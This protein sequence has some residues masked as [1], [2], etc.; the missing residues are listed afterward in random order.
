MAHLTFIHGIANKAAKERLEEAWLA[1]LRDAGG[2]DLLTEGV[3]TST[4]YWADVL[5]PHPLQDSLVS[6]ESNEDS[7]VSGAE[8][9]DLAWFSQLSVSERHAV[10][11]LAAEAGLLSSLTPGTGGEEEDPGTPPTTDGHTDFERIPLPG[12]I[13]RRLMAAFLRDV[14]HYLWNAPHSPRPGEEYLVR[15]EVRGRALEAIRAGAERSG[16]HVVVGHSL[17]SVIAYDVLQNVEEAPAVDA[18]VTIGSPLGLGEVQDRLR[19]GWSRW[20]GYPTARLSGRWVNV[21]DPLDPV[22]G[23]DPV[24]MN[25]FRRDGDG[26]I[27]D[28]N[29][30]NWGRWRHSLEKYLRGAQLRA[31]LRELLE[32]P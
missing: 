5:Y 27:S 18:L 22:C 3:S 2:V 16:P 10:R 14:H 4:C 11:E 32:L 31:Q 9:V 7:D 6:T 20:G 17:G 8:E 1:A 29:E 21:Y 26:V 23:F 25:D 19:P 30:A 28:I 15:D 24:L 12:P 13:K